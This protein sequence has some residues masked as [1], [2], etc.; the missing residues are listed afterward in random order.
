MVGDERSPSHKISYY[1]ERIYRCTQY[2]NLVKWNE[3]KESKDKDKQADNGDEP[4]RPTANRH[5]PSSSSLSL[6]GHLHW[7]GTLKRKN[8]R[9]TERMPFFIFLE[10]YQGFLNEKQQKKAAEEVAKSERKREGKKEDKEK[11]PSKPERDARGNV[12][13]EGGNIL[14]TTATRKTSKLEIE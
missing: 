2:Q 10:K 3:K 6:E 5:S 4:E 14:Q 11:Q 12:S 1:S 9:Q 7:P 8:S 13:T